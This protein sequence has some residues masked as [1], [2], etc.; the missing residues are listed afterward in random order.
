MFW[1]TL[2]GDSRN[3]YCDAKT[4]M[5]ETHVKCFNKELSLL[6]KIILPLEIIR[7]QE[8]DDSMCFQCGHEALFNRPPL[9][10]YNC[11]ELPVFDFAIYYALESRYCAA[12]RKFVDFFLV[13]I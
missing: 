5:E 8:E 3:D 9:E 7:K 12:T 6:R 10:L 11:I 13:E 1:K 2:L 4:L